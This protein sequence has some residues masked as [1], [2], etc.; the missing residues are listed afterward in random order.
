M[1]VKSA[2][3]GAEHASPGIGFERM[4]FFSDA[5]FAIAITLLV[6]DLKLPESDHGV[7][8]LRPLLLKALGFAIS[9]FV[10]GVYWIRHHRLFETL[11]RHDSRLLRV[12]LLFLAGIAFLPFPTTAVAEHVDSAWAVEL[13]ALSVAAIG[14]L[15]MLLT[16]TARRPHLMRPGETRGGT[17]RDLIREATPPAVFL[18]SCLIAPAHPVAASLSWMLIMPGLWITSRLGCWAAARIDRSA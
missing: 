4:V 13:Y 18:G 7:L 17:A 6:L 16:F 5:A 14:L 1:V 2:K 12:N 11:A 3:T 15:L 10:I 8:H 9:F